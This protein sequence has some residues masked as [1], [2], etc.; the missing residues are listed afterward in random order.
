MI[1]A[2]ILA[3]GFSRRMGT[4]KLLL[5]IG[6]LPMIE[7]IAKTLHQSEV[8]ETILIY[9][10]E[11]VKMAAEK[12]VHKTIYNH[13]AEYGQSEALKLGIRN[14][15]AASTA[16]LFAVG[17]QPLLTVEIIDHLIKLHLEHPG[18]II[19]PIFGEKPGN[20]VLFPASCREELLQLK[21]DEGGRKIM[22]KN[23]RQ[24]LEYKFEFREA[25][26]DAD[27]PESYR[28]LLRKTEPQ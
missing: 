7:R 2:I 12:Y 14:A 15:D 6:D 5:P 28:E 19:R 8:T 18:K 3:S 27:T 1:T 21:G 25:G 9:R 17:D 22:K 4:E 13:Q 10:N 23:S 24:V 26:E 11:E 20:P 16:Y